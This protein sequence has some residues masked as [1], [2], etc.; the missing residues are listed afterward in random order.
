MSCIRCE[1]CSDLIDSDEDP[2]C[3]V[4]TGSKDVVW[5]ENCRNDME[6]ELEDKCNSS[7]EFS[8]EQQ[9]VIDAAET[10]EEEEKCSGR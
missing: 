5:C 7:R 8:A 6:E 2:E 9:A 4:A 3:F 10:A 1:R